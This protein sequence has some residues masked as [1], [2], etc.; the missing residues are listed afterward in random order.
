MNNSDINELINNMY[1][2]HWLYS[3]TI[4][5]EN[6]IVPTKATLWHFNNVSTIFSSLFYDKT[7][8][9]LNGGSGLYAILAKIN[10]AK[11]VYCFEE[12]SK[13]ID[14]MN[15]VLSF[16]DI[17]I[18]IINK[19]FAAYRNDSIFII[20]DLIEKFDYVF[21]WGLMPWNLYQTISNFDIIIQSLS[22]YTKNG[23]VGNFAENDTFGK[24]YS[25]ENYLNNFKKYYK[26]VTRI[27]SLDTIIALEKIHN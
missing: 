23:I 11:E 1:Q 5:E 18:N 2:D 19:K 10:G 22:Y 15:N 17:D 4:N 27:Y 6:K 9:V 13:N 8:C 25:I 21:Y 12:D 14:L 3:Y 16:L 26:Y 24:E 7:V 20:P